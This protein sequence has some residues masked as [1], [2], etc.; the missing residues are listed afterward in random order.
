MDVVLIGAGGHAR[1]L[2][3]IFAARGDRIVGYVDP[4]YST[5]LDAPRFATADEIPAARDLFE[6]L[7][8]DGKAA[9]LKE[10]WKP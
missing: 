10:G 2:V 8:L 9:R 7:D 3:D 5:W 6:R 4:V 1:V